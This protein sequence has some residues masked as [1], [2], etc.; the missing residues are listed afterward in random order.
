MCLL[1]KLKKIVKK[2]K[3]NKIFVYFLKI[4]Y[5]NYNV[6]RKKGV[7]NDRYKEVKRPN[8]TRHS[9]SNS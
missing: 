5:Y 6:K 9:K 8:P 3:K 1:I 2:K 7:K 4:L